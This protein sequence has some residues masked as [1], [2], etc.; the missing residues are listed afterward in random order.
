LCSA[1][2]AWLKGHG[3]AY[4]ERDIAKD[5]GALR[6]MYELTRQRFVPVF[7]VNGTT[8]VRPSDEELEELL[9]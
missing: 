7:E 4:V 1:A 8:L 3:V 5:F 2:R 9:L 6:S